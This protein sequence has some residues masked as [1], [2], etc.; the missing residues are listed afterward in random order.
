LNITSAGITARGITGSGN[1]CDHAVS[2]RGDDLA[3]LTTP[4]NQPDADASDTARMGC[5]GVLY[6]SESS[7]TKSA[8]Y[9][10]LEIGQRAQRRDEGRVV[11]RLSP[12]IRCAPGTDLEL[13]IACMCP[14]GLVIDNSAFLFPHF[15]QGNSRKSQELSWEACSMPRK[16]ATNGEFCWMQGSLRK[17]GLPIGFETPLSALNHSQSLSHSTRTEFGHQ[18]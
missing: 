2:S 12:P 16:V 9:L 14:C 5:Q 11:D 15:W 6:P 17:S 10:F 7:V 13:L 1:A 4:A 18:Q 8:G 3:S